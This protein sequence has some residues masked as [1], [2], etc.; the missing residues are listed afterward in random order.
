MTQKL[1]RSKNISYSVTDGFLIFRTM[2]T[3]LYCI[4]VI[5][6]MLLEN[7]LLN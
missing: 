3:Y 6:K 2:G 1:S 4:N 7:E 5:S